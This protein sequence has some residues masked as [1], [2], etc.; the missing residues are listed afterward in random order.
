MKNI[1]KNLFI[2]LLFNIFIFNLSLYADNNNEI[3]N[4]IKKEKEIEYSLLNS[5]GIKNIQFE[6]NFIKI[7]FNDNKIICDNDNVITDNCNV[8]LNKKEVL[9]NTYSTLFFND[10]IKNI[11]K[12]EIKKI[13]I[14]SSNKSF[15]YYLIKKDDFEKNKEILEK[16]VNLNIVIID[17]NNTKID[18]LYNKWHKFNLP[19][20]IFLNNKK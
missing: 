15:Y 20:T 14:P 9:Q 18:N 19:T 5:S 12:E 6:N 8:M 11:S 1:Y 3:L 10:L 2:I 4:N 13:F 16:K 7:T 17:L